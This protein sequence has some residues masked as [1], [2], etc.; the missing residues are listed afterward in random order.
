M[1][2]HLLQA[3]L[4]ATAALLPLRAEAASASAMLV[5]NPTPPYAVVDQLLRHRDYLSLD[6]RQVTALIELSSW[7]RQARASLQVAGLDRVP[8]KSVPRFVRDDQT[9]GYTYVAPC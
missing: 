3:A 1:R 2:T 4:V 8:G 7:L 6:D 9:V 5:T